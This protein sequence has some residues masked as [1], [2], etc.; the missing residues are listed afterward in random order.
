MAEMLEEFYSTW[1]FSSIFIPR[2]SMWEVEN[3]YL[4]LGDPR[5][6]VSELCFQGKSPMEV[7]KPTEIMAVRYVWEDGLVDGVMEFPVSQPG[8]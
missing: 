4:H 1:T 3:F 5:V 8:R 6:E 7:A 2:Q